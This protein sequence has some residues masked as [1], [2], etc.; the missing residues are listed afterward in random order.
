MYEQGSSDQDKPSPEAHGALARVAQALSDAQQR[1]SFRSDPGGTVKGYEALPESVRSALE[2]MSDEE[3]DALTRAHQTF[4]DA[5]FYQ[6][7]DDEYG[8]GRVSFF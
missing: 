2:S 1:S 4:A 7:F 6:D 8:G 5:G 3:L